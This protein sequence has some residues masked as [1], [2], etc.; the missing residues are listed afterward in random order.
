MNWENREN[1]DLIVDATV[2][3]FE[4][5]KEIL[6]SKSKKGDYIRAR[7]FVMAFLSEKELD[8]RAI[9]PLINKDRTTIYH[10]LQKHHSF[11]EVERSYRREYENFKKFLKTSLRF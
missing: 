3:F 1:F 7:R 11:M 4:L 5:N 8:E 10:H 2:E 6:L 9:A